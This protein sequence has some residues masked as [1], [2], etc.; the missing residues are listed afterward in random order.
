MLTVNGVLRR[1]SATYL[2]GVMMLGTY[3][4]VALTYAFRDHQR[5]Y[6]PSS[7]DGDGDG[8]ICICAKRAAPHSH[9]RRTSPDGS[10]RSWTRCVELLSSCCWGQNSDGVGHVAE[11]CSL[12]CSDSTGRDCI[13]KSLMFEKK[14]RPESG[15]LY[16]C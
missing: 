8:D 11:H 14:P 6:G 13:L 16:G 1:A 4:V 2:E 12:A 10:S 15:A 5:E 3:L 9:T 7:G